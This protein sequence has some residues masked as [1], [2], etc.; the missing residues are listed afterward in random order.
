MNFA[1][2]KITSSFV[3]LIFALPL[4]GFALYMTLPPKPFTGDVK[5]ILIGEWKISNQTILFR[6]DG[7]CE[8][9]VPPF[10]SGGAFTVFKG[11]YWVMNDTF[12]MSS[13][14]RFFRS[15]HDD[16][17]N[18]APFVLDRSNID[19]G[20]LDQWEMYNN[21]KSALPTSYQV[22]SF[23]AATRQMLTRRDFGPTD[24]DNDASVGTVRSTWTKQP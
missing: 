23:R 16:K 1:L 22:I 8:S 15:Q 18:D 20:N 13:G 9:V 24:S 3:Q 19:M 2:K 7:T 5:S 12:T 10:N 4:L 21:D 11:T 6:V 17:G 14:K